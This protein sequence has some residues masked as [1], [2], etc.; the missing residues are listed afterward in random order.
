VKLSIEAKYTLYHVETHL[1]ICTFRLGMQTLSWP[2]F[3]WIM[4]ESFLDGGKFRSRT[5][6]SND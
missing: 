3:F 2:Q 1:V 6:F 5:G 4:M